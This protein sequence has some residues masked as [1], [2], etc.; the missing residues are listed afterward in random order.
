MINTV[1]IILYLFQILDLIR[2]NKAM[3]RKDS[4]EN[5]EEVK[6]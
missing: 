3:K 4:K 1:L 5:E 6:R 2:N